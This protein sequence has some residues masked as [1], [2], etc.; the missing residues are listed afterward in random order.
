MAGGQILS[1][2]SKAKKKRRED[3][4]P[5]DANQHEWLRQWNNAGRA[6]AAHRRRELMHLSDERALAASEALLSLITTVTPDPSR[7]RWSGLVEQQALFH[8][9]PSR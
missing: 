6:L 4:P 5:E 9:K 3:V 1:A 7:R 2:R 8:R